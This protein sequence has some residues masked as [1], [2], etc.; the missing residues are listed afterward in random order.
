MD[1]L[2]ITVVRSNWAME[3][4][5][6][7]K[8]VDRDPVRSR[9]AEHLDEDLSLEALS[10]VYDWVELNPR[11]ESNGNASDS[12]TP[13]RRKTE[14]INFVNTRHDLLRLVPNTDL[15]VI[16][17]YANDS[18]I[19]A[20]E[21]SHRPCLLAWNAWGW[22][23]ESRYV[24]DVLLDH[25]EVFVP[26]LFGKD[27]LETA[28]LAARGIKRLRKTRAVCVGKWPSGTVKS[29][30]DVERMS[31]IL[32]FEIIFVPAS[33]Y[34]AA[35]DKLSEKELAK[36]L[37]SIASRFSLDTNSSQA[38]IMARNYLAVKQLVEKYDANCF[39]IDCL[40]N[41]DI[42]YS[43]CAALGLLEDEGVIYACEADI[44]S[45]VPHLL[46]NG[47]SGKGG[48]L[49][50]FNM[51]HVQHAEIAN[52]VIGIEHDVLPTSW[53]TSKCRILDHH[54]SGKGSTLWGELREK[55]V[56]V[57]GLSRSGQHL[58]AFTGEI[59]EVKDLVHCRMG[60]WI[61]TDQPIR[62]VLRN[63]VG[64]HQIVMPGKWLRQLWLAA[65][66]S[67]FTPLMECDQKT[68]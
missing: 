41:P 7:A 52:N 63:V 65:R 47:M 25:P 36:A 38:S 33:E 32:G 1:R 11:L 27:D 34:V 57:C 67:G 5:Y 53:C 56:T 9:E 48:F 44:P 3:K 59:I 55:E 4:W 18:V 16:S 15:F 21:A 62:D 42:D 23:Y 60:L 6:I 51:V 54:G 8:G 14:F 64:H 66:W 50:N 22:D 28:L 12:Q 17:R 26:H 30:M 29:G 24:R 37:S 13:G 20:I 45:L 58:H 49:G 31:D 2:R 39:T 61:K 40:S 43:P 68:R 19:E 46:I 10:K 35:N